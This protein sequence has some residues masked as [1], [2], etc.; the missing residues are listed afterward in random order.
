LL[1]TQRETATLV[2]SEKPAHFA[3]AAMRLQYESTRMQ[4]RQRG[5]EFNLHPMSRKYRV[6][7]A[8][9]R[10]P[11]NG[12]AILGHCDRFALLGIAHRVTNG[13]RQQS[14]LEPR[15]WQDGPVALRREKAGNAKRACGEDSDADAGV[16]WSEGT[17]GCQIKASYSVP[18]G[19]RNGWAEFRPDCNAW[20]RARL[21]AGTGLPPRG[22]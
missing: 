2:F 7:L 1:E 9:N 11:L 22:R 18:D 16:A 8:V 4:R 17:A 19:C 20:M 21:L 6:L 10:A 13:P 5:V 3:G 14:D 12:Y 15:K